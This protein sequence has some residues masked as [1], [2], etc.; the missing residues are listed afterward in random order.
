MKILKTLLIKFGRPK[1]NTQGNA[2]MSGRALALNI[3]Y[4]VTDIAIPVV[5]IL[6]AAIALVGDSYN[7]FLYFQF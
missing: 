2:V 1:T 7:P 4:R 3:I 6:L 5:T